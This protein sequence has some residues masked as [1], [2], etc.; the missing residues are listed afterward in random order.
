M[1]DRSRVETSPLPAHGGAVAFAR[2]A[3]VHA[4]GADSMLRRRILRVGGNRGV[5]AV[6]GRRRADAGTLGEQVPRASV[7]SGDEIEARRGRGPR[8][9]IRREAGV[10]RS[11]GRRD[12]GL[13]P[14]VGESEAEDD[15]GDGE[16]DGHGPAGAYRPFE[17]REDGEKD[18]LTPDW[19]ID[20][21]CRI[22]G[23]NLPTVDEPII[24]GLLD[25][26]T[27]SNR[28]PNIPAEKTF[29]RRQD[30]LKQENPWKGS[31]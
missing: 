18:G 26:C 13:G 31:T 15:D 17:P 4:K 22:F 21:G 1:V 2:R 16:G 30:G 28:R 19:I 7:S 24:R 12:D 14:A 8:V 25:P 29:D 27:N 6:R 10:A 20:A 9:P 23:L 11:G 3:A 5:G